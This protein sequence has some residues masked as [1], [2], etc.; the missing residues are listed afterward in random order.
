MYY[1]V[2]IH[3]STDKLH[4]TDEIFSDNIL[5]SINRTHYPELQGNHLPGIFQPLTHPHTNTNTH[6][7]KIIFSQELLFQPGID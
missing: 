1:T 6:T 4:S 2:L 5:R 7:Q 3:N